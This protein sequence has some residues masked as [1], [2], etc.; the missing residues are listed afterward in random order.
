MS[1]EI[2]NRLDAAVSPVVGVMLMLVVVIII[3]AVVSAFSAGISTGQKTTPSASIDVIIDT[4]IDDT[5]GGTTTKMIFEHLSGD[6]LPTKDLQII[7]YYT[8]PD[9]TVIR[10]IQD[11][12]SPVTR[13]YSSARYT[14]V[15]F[16]NDPKVGRSGYDPIVNFGNFTWSTGDLL[17][18][19]SPAGTSALLGFNTSDSAYGF[20]PGAIVEIKILHTPSSRYIY[21]HEVTV[22]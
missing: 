14:R 4:S 2:N 1:K 18:T 20:K 6:P 11:S 15:P 22:E 12:S 8:A 21:N 16:L 3:A 5:M 13:L 19:G 17:S 9:G 7:T 10:H